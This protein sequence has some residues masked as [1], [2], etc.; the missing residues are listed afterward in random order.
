[1]I[2]GRGQRKGVPTENQRVNEPSILGRVTLMRLVKP[3]FLGAGG[4]G[5]G[6]EL[7]R[8]PLGGTGKNGHRDE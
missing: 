8:D 5:G 7:G 4:G 6:G 3:T 2:M 1:M